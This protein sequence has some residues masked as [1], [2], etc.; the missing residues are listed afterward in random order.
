MDKAWRI[1]TMHFIM[2]HPVLIVTT[3]HQSSHFFKKKWGKVIAVVQI[4]QILCGC[5]QLLVA[6]ASSRRHPSLWRAKLNR[7]QK[8]NK[9]ACTALGMYIQWR[10]ETSNSARSKC[11]DES[12]HSQRSG[13][14]NERARL[15][16]IGKMKHTKL[17]V[18][19]GAWI[20]NKKNKSL[21]CGSG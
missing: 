18:L 12:G 19:P 3:A 16:F 7:E 10:A 6:T 11:P 15:I 21:G 5:S 17:A 9:A 4:L 13:C 8:M 2:Y 14:T 1:L 20:K